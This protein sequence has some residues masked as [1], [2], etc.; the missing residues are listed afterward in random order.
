M[1][2]VHLAT[3]VG[4]EN[5]SSDVRQD[6]LKRIGERV[7]VLLGAAKKDSESKVKAELLAL[8]NIVRDMDTRVDEIVKQLDDIEENPAQA[9]EPQTVAQA[10]AKLEQQWGK[11]LG[12]LKQ[13]LHQTIYAHNHNADLMKH[14]KDAL[15]S[16][17]TELDGSQQSLGG[18]SERVKLAKLHI[19]KAEALSRG[20]QKRGASEKDKLKPL[21]QRLAAIEQQ[22]SVS[23]FPM[24]GVPGMPPHPGM[25][26]GMGAPGMPPGIHLAAAAAAAGTGRMPNPVAAGAM[27]PGLL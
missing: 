27:P 17:R 14:Q 18:D 6:I 12:K 23:R 15:D 16:L 22:I 9:V 1:A 5:V 26:P 10:L 8:N 11:E 24:G 21:F 25:M 3:P 7:T 2:A 19:T 20:Q 4:M 13:E